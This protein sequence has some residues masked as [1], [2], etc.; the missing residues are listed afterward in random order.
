VSKKRTI[1]ISIVVGIAGLIALYPLGKQTLTDWMLSVPETPFDKTP[2]PLAPDYSQEKYWA[3]L[4]NKKDG[5]DWV[6]VNSGFTDEQA[7]APVDVFFIYPT[8]AFYG[9]YWVAGFDNWLH[10]AAV[11]YGILPQQASA[12]NATGKI[13]A[14]RYRS[15]RMG[16]WM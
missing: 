14:P 16:I 7:N 15:I 9:D 10:L 11:D 5:A 6:P 12:F 4:P 1:V 2:L 13:Y 8:A 3:A